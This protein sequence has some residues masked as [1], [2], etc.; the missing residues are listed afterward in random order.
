MRK[1]VYYNENVE[2]AFVSCF[3]IE[4]Y[5][6]WRWGIFSIYESESEISVYNRLF[7]AK[8]SIKRKLWLDCNSTGHFIRFCEWVLFVPH[9]RWESLKKKTK[10]SSI[11]KNRKD[12]IN[13]S[14]APTE[15][16]KFQGAQEFKAQS[17]WLKTN[18]PLREGILAPKIIILISMCSC[19]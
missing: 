3:Y 17:K 14:I 19:S 10:T 2:N 15:W 11:N 18:P 1:W 13:K 12:K 7:N 8:I 9:Y 5:V 4:I 16:F 6:A